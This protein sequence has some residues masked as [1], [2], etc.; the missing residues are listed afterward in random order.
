MKD[1]DILAQNL[2]IEQKQAE[3]DGFISC[4]ITYTELCELLLKNIDFVAKMGSNDYANIIDDMCC[5]G[6]L[7]KAIANY[8]K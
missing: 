6:S 5:C 1:L 8:T 2:I 4:P 7:E 3:I